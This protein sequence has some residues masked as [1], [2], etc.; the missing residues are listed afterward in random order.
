MASMNVS[1]PDPMRDW[2]QRRIDSGQYASVSDY[3]RDLIRRDQTQAEERQALVEA[4]VQ[5]ERSG[6]SKRTIPDILAAMKTAHDATD[7]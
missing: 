2:V 1:V 3:V 7:G 6:V 4:L 5:G